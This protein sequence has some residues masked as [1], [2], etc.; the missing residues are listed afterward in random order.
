MAYFDKP[1]SE[2]TNTNLSKK[3]EY[4][5]TLLCGEA[6]RTSE[7]A[8]RILREG[9]GISSKKEL[10]ENLGT[11]QAKMEL[12]RIHGNLSSENVKKT[13]DSAINM[14]CGKR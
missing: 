14:I 3:D 5:L 10:E 9:H 1:D 7:I 13:H 6:K 2:I 8:S 11:L 4:Y 12:A